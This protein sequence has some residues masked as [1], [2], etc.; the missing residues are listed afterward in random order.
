MTFGFAI[1]VVG[2]SF[3]NFDAF[4][5]PLRI[6]ELFAITVFSTLLMWLERVLIK[7]L[8]EISFED[9]YAKRVF[10][11]GVKEG[12]IGL[13]KNVR[14]EKPT[15][16]VVEG[17]ISYYKDITN[18]TLMGKKIYPI[19]ERLPKL[20]RDKG[21]S[22]LLISPLKNDDYRNDLKL[23]SL[24]AEAGVHVYMTT[25]A[26]EWDGKSDLDFGDMKEVDI[27]DLLPRSEIMV[28]MKVLREQLTGR[29]VEQWR[30]SLFE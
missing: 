22:V 23:Q 9:A 25:M 7:Q 27:E 21:V 16:F 3:L 15:R 28:D 4:F 29:M 8:Y 19:D 14:N 1:I 2:R 6:R 20:M 13:A 17:F 12:G 10:I 5:L 30:Y 11:F 24:V 26:K 18:K